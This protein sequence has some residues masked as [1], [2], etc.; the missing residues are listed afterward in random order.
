MGY[1]FIEISDGEFNIDENNN[2]ECAKSNG[3]IV[4]GP[5]EVDVDKNAGDPDD[6][7]LLVTMNLWLIRIKI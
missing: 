6:V 1:K 4:K 7:I 3:V 5:H 2:V